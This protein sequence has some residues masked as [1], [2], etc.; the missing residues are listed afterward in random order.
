M[1][2]V[3]VKRAEGKVYPNLGGLYFTAELESGKHSVIVVVRAR[4]G[5]QVIVQNA[6]NRCWKGIGK[7]YPSGEAA[8]AAYK[9]AEIRAMISEALRLDQQLR[10]PAPIGWDK[11]EGGLQ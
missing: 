1:S 7:S 8:L 6:S 11:I 9:T 4:G 2:A 3:L 10:H 5:L